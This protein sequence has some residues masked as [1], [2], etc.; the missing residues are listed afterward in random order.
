M[1]PNP[2]KQFNETYKIN[3]FN[4]LQSTFWDSKEK[5]KQN[6]D[7][8]VSILEENDKKPEGERIK[9]NLT[10]QSLKESYNFLTN[11]EEREN[12]LSFLKYYYFLSE[13][14]TLGQLKKNYNNKLFPYYIFTIK[15]KEKQQISTLIV[16]YVKKLITISYKDKEFYTIKSESIITV[17]KKF[18][19]TIIIM[20]KNEN[21]DKSKNKPKD[22]FKE[23]TFEPEIT[24]QIDIIYTIISYFVKSIEDKNFY[25][26]LEDDSY[27][28]FGIILR[29]KIIKDHRVKVLGKD[30][31]YAILG[32]SMIIIYKNEEMKDIR[33]V[34]PLYPFF[35]RVSYIDKEKK[36]IFKYPSREQSLSFYDNEHYIMWM[37]TLKEIFNR[38]IKSKMG[39]LEYFQANENKE[40]EKIIKG[41][42]VEILCAQEEVK[43]IKKKLEDNKN[44]F[45][46]KIKKK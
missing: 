38:R 23:T 14:I 3:H 20:S 45:L 24:Q 32:P 40:K 1:D 22:E 28:P 17:N 27:R 39:V 15:I 11:K 9:Y 44:K 42:D 33:N 21:Y 6:Y 43:E 35:M 10:K 25:D 12:Y 16:D 19:T 8:L 29:T 4:V 46:E 18:G 31:R 13:P 30:D 41:I 2:T 36:I 26:L 5:I 34:L 7:S 37:T